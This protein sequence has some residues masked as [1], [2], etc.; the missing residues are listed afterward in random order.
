MDRLLRAAQTDR[1]EEDH[2]EDQVMLSDDAVIDIVRAEQVSD[3]TLKLTF[4]DG[5]E[6]VIDF[7]HFL[8]ASGNPMI[9]AYL[10]PAKFANFRLEYGD[11]LWD[12][13]GLCFPIAD[14]YEQR[15]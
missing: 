7:E 12:D 2:A 13:Y 10:D 4:S 11:L 5:T 14:L 3:Y 15:I 1:A 9:R 6:R 8:S